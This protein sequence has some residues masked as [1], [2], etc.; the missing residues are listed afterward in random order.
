M[1]EGCE[2]ERWYAFEGLHTINRY[3]RDIIG[4]TNSVIEG[5]QGELYDNSGRY[6]VAVGPKVMNPNH[7]DDRMVYAEEMRYGSKLDVLLQHKETE[8]I[9]Y[10]RA[11]VGDCKNHTYSNGIYQTGRPFPNGD[12]Y[13][14][15]Y[16]DGSVIE[17][18]GAVLPEGLSDFKIVY[19]MVQN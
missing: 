5:S 18:C 2:P 3:A 19:I 15:Q 12:E 9:Y 17:F 16:D 13:Y 6:W 8:R 4:D 10:L 7:A 11:V 1:P 14:R